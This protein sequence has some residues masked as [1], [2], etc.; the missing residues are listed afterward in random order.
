VILCGIPALANTGTEDMQAIIAR[1]RAAA[2]V[3]SVEVQL[4]RE[5]GARVIGTG[6]AAHRQ[7]VLGLG[8][9]VF[10]EPWD[11]GADLIEQRQ[12]SSSRPKPSDAA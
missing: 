4:A 6:R 8:A 2:A 5:A 3:G 9:E 10:V 11:P 7:T 12:L 1:E